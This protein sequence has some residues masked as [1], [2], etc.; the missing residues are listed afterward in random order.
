[1]SK[2]LSQHLVQGWVK[3]WSK[4]VARHNWTKFWRKKGNFCLILS[5]LSHSP[6]WK[7]KIVEI[8]KRKKEE[9]VDQVLTQKKAKFGPR[10]DYIYIYTHTF[11]IHIHTWPAPPLEASLLLKHVISAQ[12]YIKIR[13]WGGGIFRL[14]SPFGCEHGLAIARKMHFEFKPDKNRF[15]VCSTWTKYPCRGNGEY[16][17]RNVLKTGT[18]WIRS[19]LCGVLG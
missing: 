5:F 8:Q 19:M 2:R 1:M 15:F 12:S 16:V 14:F 9:N 6:F 13:F 4:H 7:K 17:E 11:S 10:F 3:T 18:W